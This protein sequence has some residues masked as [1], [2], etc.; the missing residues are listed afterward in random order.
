VQETAEVASSSYAARSMCVF[1]VIPEAAKFMTV[2]LDVDRCAW[3][4]QACAQGAT[5][6]G[7]AAY[8]VVFTRDLVL[9]PH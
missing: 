3:G 4:I 5:A 6:E 9:C 7:W 8:A 1:A 2:P